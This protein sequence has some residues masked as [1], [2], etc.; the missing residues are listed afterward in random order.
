MNGGHLGWNRQQGR[1]T[2]GPE[3]ETE[4]ADRPPQRALHHQDSLVKVVR[5][6]AR[7]FPDNLPI[8]SPGMLPTSYLWLFACG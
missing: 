2:V 6:Q 8:N 1:H 7:L 5:I 3:S 4:P